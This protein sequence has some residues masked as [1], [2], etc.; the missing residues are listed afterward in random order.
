M[1]EP[2][3]RTILT[4]DTSGR[5]VPMSTVVAAAGTVSHGMTGMVADGMRCVA[6][7][8]TVAAAGAIAHRV[9]RVVADGVIRGRHTVRC[10]IR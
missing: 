3:R 2:E 8:A 4:V 7:Y 9:A 1:L 5:A 10:S 6:M